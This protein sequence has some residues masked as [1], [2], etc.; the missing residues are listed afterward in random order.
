MATDQEFAKLVNEE[1]AIGLMQ[2]L[3]KTATFDQLVSNNV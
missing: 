2:K 3:A 1:M